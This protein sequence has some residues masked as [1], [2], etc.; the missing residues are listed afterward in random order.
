MKLGLIISFL[1]Y[2]VT[3]MLML[4]QGCNGC[5]EKER[6]GLL[7]I[8][9]Y[10][11]SQQD[12]GDSYND[13]E[14]GSWVDDRDSN[15]CVWDRVECSSGHI[16]ELFFDRL[17]FWTS[18]PKMLN[19]SLFCPF[20]EL[21]LLDLSDNDI[22]GWIGNEDFPRLTKLET[23]GLSSNNLNSSILSSLNG[24]TALTTLYLDF[25]NIDNNFFPQGFPRLKRLESLDLSGNDYLNSSILPSLN[26]LTALTTLNLGFNSMKNFYVQGFSRSKELEVLDL[27]Y[28]ELNC[29][30]ITSLH[31][32]ISL[33]SLILNDNE[34]NCSLSTLDFAKFS[35][36]ELLDLG[37]NQ[38]IGSLH[39]ED[40]QHLKNLKML[41]LSDN[42]MKG[43]IEGLCNLKD[44]EELDISK[45]MFGAKLPECLSNLTNL[46][47]LDLSHNLFGGNFPSFT[48]NLTSLTFL[49]LYENYM[50]GS[51]SLIN[52]ANHSNLQHLYISSKNSIGVHIETEKT[53]WFPKFQLKS[54]ILRN[55]NLN[56]KK[57]SVIPTFLSYQY[58][59]IVMDLS[60]NNIGSLPSWLINNVG[61]Q[62]LDLSNNNFSGLLPEDI[63]IFLPSVTYMNFSSNNFEGNIPSSI[64]KMKKLKY[65]DL[66]QNHFSGELP[67]QLAADCN[68]LQYLIL[69]N[70]SL[71]G[72]IPKFVNMVVLFLNNN[73]FSGTLDDVLGKGN[74]RRLILLSI[75][76]NSITGKIPSS[77]GMFSHMQ[78]LFMG[79]NQLEGQIPIEIS[80]MPW[81]H[82]LD[83][84]QNKLIGAI[85]KLSSFKYLRFLYLQQNDLSGSKP[86][87]LSE[88]SKLQLLD[89]RENKLSGKI[90]NWMDKLS[91]L[92]VLLLGGNNFEGEIPIQLC[93]LKNITIMDLSR[94]MLNA[95]IPSCFQNMSFGMRQHVHN[96]DDDG[97]IFEFSMYKAPTAI[98]FNASLLIRHPWIGNSLKNLQFEVE[99]RTK[100]NEYFYKGKVLEIMT[101][102][103]LSCNN[104]TGVIPSQIGDLQQI[105]A[106]NLSHNHLSG[107]IPITFSNLTQIESLDLS[108][109]NLSGKIPNELTQLNFLE[110][111]NVSYNNLSGTPPSTGQFGGFV[112]ENYIGNPGLCGPFLNRKC[113]HVESS[114]SSQSNDDGEKETMVDMITFYWS[115]TASYI[116]ILLAFITVL[117][118]NPRWR[119]AWFYYISKFMRRFFPTFPLY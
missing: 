81:L 85:P 62:Y 59:L 16:T 91:E 110:I 10:I 6:I 46:R 71:C 101:G 100:H 74:N 29:N 33:R 84:S 119:M 52:L 69:S 51:F 15:C 43:S 38:F 54:L 41:R 26:G 56:M 99:F 92:R 114:A 113:E 67:K 39:V 65:L 23:L 109:N 76:N 1:L 86:S 89:L 49:S 12:E 42:Q 8:K 83:L 106:L 27:S 48:T 95:S 68:N 3:L 82:I 21:R 30:I 55:C 61:I 116:T 14:L 35:Q 37:G 7:E 98:S 70:N 94:N 118:I 60:S 107:P 97:S 105:R 18:D 75:S 45:N 2:F 104:L 80:N 32:F 79:Q 57:G 28:N 24:L 66:S 20:K 88:G 73:N 11:L 31:G 17:L 22:Q 93:H 72:N 9:H 44:L 78:F 117:C 112:E 36:L 77:I 47:I 111:F 96:D 5:L 87:E 13:K 53:K 108:Y 103:D 19:V 115:F 102:L 4:T 50:Q 64:C 40:V 90:P 58:N 25:N 63:G 34:F